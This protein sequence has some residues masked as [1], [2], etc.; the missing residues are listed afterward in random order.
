MCVITQQKLL[1]T[2]HTSSAHQNVFILAG[3]WSYLLQKDMIREYFGSVKEYCFTQLG[4]CEPQRVRVEA[5]LQM[6]SRGE[7][8]TGFLLHR[9]KQNSSKQQP[10]M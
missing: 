9:D 1:S 7:T 2:P 3:F 5:E 4:N 8:H 10:D 6:E